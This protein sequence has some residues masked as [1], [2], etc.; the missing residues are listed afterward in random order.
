[1]DASHINIIT[2]SAQIQIYEVLQLIAEAVCKPLVQIVVE[3]EIVDIVFAIPGYIADT[4]SLAL[5]E[6]YDGVWSRQFRSVVHCIDKQIF[7]H[8]GIPDLIAGYDIPKQ[9]CSILEV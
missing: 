5:V 2:H 9:Y 8:P 1:M 3:S 4:F 6:L 7:Q